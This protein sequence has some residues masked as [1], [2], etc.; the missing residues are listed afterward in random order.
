MSPADGK[1]KDIP[2]DNL[3]EKG[4][5]HRTQHGGRHILGTA[6]EPGADRP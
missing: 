6:C 5:E 4:Q 2:E 1:T 3:K